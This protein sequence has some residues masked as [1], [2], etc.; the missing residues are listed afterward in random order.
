MKF[1]RDFFLRSLPLSLV[2]LA[3]W[4]SSRPDWSDSRPGKIGKEQG[5]D[6]NQEEN[7]QIGGDRFICQPWKQNQS[8]VNNAPNAY[9]NSESCRWRVGKKKLKNYS[10]G[11]AGCQQARDQTDRPPEGKVEQ[12]FVTTFQKLPN[13]KSSVQFC[14]LPSCGQSRAVRSGRC[15][16]PQVLKK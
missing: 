5:Q 7:I 1:R 14:V 16:L 4:A 13:E 12:K 9:L 10:G 15:Q 11:P 6:G 8:I 3:I 2:S